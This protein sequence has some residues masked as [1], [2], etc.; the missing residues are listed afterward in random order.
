MAASLSIKA[1]GR[2]CFFGDHQDYLGLPVIAATIDRYVFIEATP[3]NTSFLRIDLLDFSRQETIA[4]NE[5]IDRLAPSR[6]FPFCSSGFGARGHHHKQWLSHKN[7]GR[8]PHSSWGVQLIRFGGG[9][10]SFTVKNR[11]T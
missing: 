11:G 7:L 1:P 9:L 5:T 4:L 10:D 2:V 8:H 6:L 3:I